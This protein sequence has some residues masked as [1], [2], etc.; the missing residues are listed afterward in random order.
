MSKT[1]ETKETELKKKEAESKKPV[2][3]FLTPSGTSTATVSTSSS[4]KSKSVITLA[5][6]ITIVRLALLP[7]IL[8]FYISGNMFPNSDFFFLWGK[9][10][11]L[12]LFVVAA[13]TDYVDGYIARKYD[14]VSDLGKLLDPI[15]DKL[16]TTL[17]FILIVTDPHIVSASGW[18]ASSGA[19]M[20]PVWFAA[21]VIMVCLS[22]DFIVSFIRQIAAEKS[23]VY[24]ANW[25][26]KI[27]TTVQLIAQIFVMYFAISFAHNHALLGGTGLF[28]D[29]FSFICVFLLVCVVALNVYSTIDYII[30]YKEKVKK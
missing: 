17:G 9:L 25:S 22:R 7:F 8:F 1:A 15:A 4:A 3:S 24:A 19:G 27:K 16:L 12:V 6:K 2:I 13:A 23:I 26:G 20:F 10:I 18:W 21:I 5:T 30:K 29:I 11:A 14:Q 28:H